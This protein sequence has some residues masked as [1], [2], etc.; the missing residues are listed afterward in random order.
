MGFQDESLHA[1][2]IIKMF[3]NEFYNFPET[4]KH[5]NVNFLNFLI[6]FNQFI[7]KKLPTANKKFKRAFYYVKK[8]SL[9]IYQENLEECKLLY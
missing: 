1:Q 8:M 9:E 6:I 2:T 4:F 3:F 7:Y 5:L